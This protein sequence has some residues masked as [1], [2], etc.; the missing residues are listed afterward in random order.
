MRP[1]SEIS[2][3][4]WRA[5]SRTA[6]VCSRS[7][8]AGR[9][10]RGAAEDW[11]PLPP[12]RAAAT[13]EARESRSRA[14]FS[15]DR[16][17][18]YWRPASANVTVSSASEPSRSSTSRVRTCW[19]TGHFHSISSRRA[20]RYSPESTMNVKLARREGTLELPRGRPRRSIRPVHAPATS[21]EGTTD[22][23]DTGGASP[24]RESAPNSSSRPIGSSG[25]I[26]SIDAASGARRGRGR[27][28]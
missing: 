2:C 16:S 11:R 24:P 19:A 6:A 8:A 12:R 9:A 4:F 25:P 3:P 15:P 7:L 13:K 23:L 26:S 18:S 17:I 28:R 22:L 20:G 1:R 21:A 14:A 27:R 5:H 10:D